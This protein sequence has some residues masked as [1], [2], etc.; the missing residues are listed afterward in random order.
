MPP[1]SRRSLPPRT[2]GPPADSIRATPAPPVPCRSPSA[3]PPAPSSSAER[4]TVPDD[5]PAASL[6][7]ARSSRVAVRTARP[8]RH[9]AHLLLRLSRTLL[10]SRTL[11]DPV[12]SPPHRLPETSR[13][14]PATPP[15]CQET[16]VVRLPSALR[17]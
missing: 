6:R 4:P 13:L 16:S 9:I 3:P 11:A 8:L 10:P 14:R 5:K 7:C 15:E 1:E 17:C 12:R 2:A